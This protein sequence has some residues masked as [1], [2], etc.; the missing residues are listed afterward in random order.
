P[1]AQPGDGGRPGVPVPP[2]GKAQ[3]SDSE[4]DAF[5][6]IESVL[7]RDGSME[8]RPGRKV[9]TRRPVLLIPGQIDAAL[10][11]R[12]VTMKVRINPDGTVANVTVSKT[13]GSTEVDQ[14]CLVSMYDWW[15]EPRLDTAGK[16][17]P[18][19]IFFTINFR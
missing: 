19:T 1:A 10:G 13:S 8:V 11:A 15:F 12:S 18:D 5:N 3:E 7:R 2:A 9:K 14:P 17:V 16:P 6:Q 4:V